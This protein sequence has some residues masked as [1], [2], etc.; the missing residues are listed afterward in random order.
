M[1]K[2]ILEVFHYVLQKI[3]EMLPKGVLGAIFVRIYNLARGL[4]KEKKSY[5]LRLKTK[6]VSL[7]DGG[8]LFT[9]L[10]GFSK[11]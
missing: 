6:A 3:K 7:L 2:L 5:P 1:D 10:N 8:I 9:R 4:F 11:N